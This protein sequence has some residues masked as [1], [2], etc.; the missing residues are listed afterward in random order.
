[1]VRAAMVFLLFLALL[2]GAVLPFQAGINAQLRLTLGHPI[3]TALV[4]FA[5]G[6]AALAVWCVVGQVPLPTGASLAR[7]A[8]W[9]WL[10]GLL[11]A[12]Y[13]SATV[14]LAPRLGATALVALIVAGQLF[15]SV[16]LDHFGLVGY[17]RRPAD[18]GRIVGVVLLMA[19][20]LLVVRR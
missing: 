11:G 14:V 10:G 19:G 9:H 2:A 6:T 18:L 20:V 4:S 1:M 16:L 8:W 12:L 5:V 17:A 15:A 13:I 3:L 7:G